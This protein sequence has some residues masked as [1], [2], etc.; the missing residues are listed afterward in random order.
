[1]N[2]S[3]TSDPT[4]DLALPGVTSLIIKNN[5]G[6]ERKSLPPAVAFEIPLAKPQ[7][8][9]GRQS[10]GPP[11]KMMARGNVRGGLNAK[12]LSCGGLGVIGL[13]LSQTVD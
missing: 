10:G 11:F 3:N 1:M 4:A 9:S 12:I 6:N 2:L 13:P 5:K 7:L 8:I